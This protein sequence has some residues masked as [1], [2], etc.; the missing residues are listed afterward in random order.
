MEISFGET[1]KTARKS[2]GLTQKDLFEKTGIS[3]RQLVG[4]EKNKVIPRVFN[5]KKLS[6]ALDIPYDYLFN[7]S[8]RKG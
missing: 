7:L 4:F 2:K 5:I 8:V 6:D 3:V 1:I